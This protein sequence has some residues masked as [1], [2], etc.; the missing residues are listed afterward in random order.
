FPFEKA[1]YAAR[2]PGFKV[3]F[4]GHPLIDR[5]AARK[6]SPAEPGIPLLLLLPGSRERELRKHLPVMISAARR[7]AASDSVQVLMVIPHESLKTTAR[8]HLASAPEI[9]LQIGALEDALS[10]ATAAIA[11]SGTV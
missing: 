4:V 2:K 7:L 11:S 6:S 8:A 9:R 10:S 3:E 5:Y 1:W